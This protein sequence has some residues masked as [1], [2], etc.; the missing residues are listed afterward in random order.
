M[1]E[2]IEDL[3]DNVALLEDCERRSMLCLA[4]MGGS[5]TLP[6]LTSNANGCLTCVLAACKS[7][8]FENVVRRSSKRLPQGSAYI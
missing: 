7:E 2:V 4:G 5:A 3:K 6:S 8:D 1:E